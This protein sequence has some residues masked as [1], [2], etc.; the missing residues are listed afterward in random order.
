MSSP[1]DLIAAVSAGVRAAL[2]EQLRAEFM[3]AAAAASRHSIGL[4]KAMLRV[5]ELRARL[6][7]LGGDVA[8]AEVYYT[9]ADLARAAADAV[10]G[11][12]VRRDDPILD[13]IPLGD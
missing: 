10:R 7:E 5:Q 9:P 8:P 1:L 11:G 6:A 3:E 13:G 4:V 2:A 12:F